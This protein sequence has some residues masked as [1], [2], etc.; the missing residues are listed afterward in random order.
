MGMQGNAFKKT[1]VLIERRCLLGV[2]CVQYFQEWL[3]ES[4]LIN[5]AD[6]LQWEK[7]I[8][9]LKA[10]NNTEHSFHKTKQKSNITWSILDIQIASHSYSAN[11]F[12]KIL[13]TNTYE[14]INQWQ[15]RNTFML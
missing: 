8:N 12:E 2:F 15:L 14:R 4:I 6:D 13:K 5:F 3:E 11:I 7:I 10:G 9:H 1:P